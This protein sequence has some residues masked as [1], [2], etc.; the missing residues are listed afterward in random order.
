VN[1]PARA[2]SAVSGRGWAAAHEPGFV[3]EFV[4]AGAQPSAPLGRTSSFR[5]CRPVKRDS[6]I[7]PCVT[8]LRHAPCLIPLVSRLVEIQRV[9]CP[10]AWWNASRRSWMM[11]APDADAFVAAA[12]GRLDA[13]RETAVIAVGD[14][15][16]VMRAAAS[17]CPSTNQE[18]TSWCVA[19]L[20]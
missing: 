14:A 11:T 16:W 10:R 2:P 5:Q 18:D 4:H 8:S 12:H 1:N 7:D 3:P 19:Q 9:T 15:R 17:T 13:I 6:Q 20:L